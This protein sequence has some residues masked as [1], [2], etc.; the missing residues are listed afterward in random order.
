MSVHAAS[1]NT[2]AAIL[3]RLI[4]HRPEDFSRDVAEY[5]LSI[6]FDQQDVSRMNELSERAQEGKLSGDEQA[7]L[8]SYID[9]GNLLAALQ[10]KARLVLQRTAKPTP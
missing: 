7:E 9:V 8:D 5:L 1:Q 2:E 10:S 4:Q 6:R 3:A